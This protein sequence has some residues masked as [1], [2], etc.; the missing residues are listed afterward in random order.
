MY[1]SSAKTNICLDSAITAKVML[2]FLSYKQVWIFISGEFK[3]KHL[4]FASV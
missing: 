2:R 3:K 1:F 4:L